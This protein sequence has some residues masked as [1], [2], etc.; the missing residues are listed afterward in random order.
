MKQA[1]LVD[2]DFLDCSYWKGGKY[3]F[4]LNVPDEYPHKPPDVKLVEKVSLFTWLS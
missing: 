1:E 3:N 4:E 2:T